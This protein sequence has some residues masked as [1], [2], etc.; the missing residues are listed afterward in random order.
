[1]F[2]YDN[3][4]HNLLRQAEQSAESASADTGAATD[5]EIKKIIEKAGRLEGLSHREV[6]QLLMC[7]DQKHLEL[8]FQTAA[9]VKAA[10]YGN[11]VV[12][13]APLYVSDWCVNKCAYCNY[14][15]LHQFGRSR[16]TQEQVRME[17]E[18]LEKMGHKRLALEA[19]Q[20]SENC[21]IE[22]ILE[23][24]DTIYSMKT[25]KGAIRRVNVNVAATSVEDYKKLKAAGIG[26]YI[27]FQ[28]TYHRPTYEKVHIAGPKKDFDYHLTALD[29]AME[30]GLDDVGG[31]A[32]FG[33]YDPYFEVLGL[34][35]HNEHLEKN[36]GVGFHTVSV[37]RLCKADGAIAAG[38]LYALSD[39][40]FMK[41]TAVLR[42]AIPFTG[43]IV[44]TRE[45]YALRKKLINIGVS[46]I[47]AGSVT[48]VGGY[49][50]GLAA[51]SVAQF[52][53]NDNSKI[54][55]IASWL[56]DE[57]LIPSFCTACYRSGRTGGRFMGL[58][59]TGKIKNVCQPN[60][61]MTLWEYAMD[62]GS[63]DFV[64][65]TRALIKSELENIGDEKIREL[66]AGNI[67]KI[68]NGQRDL[69]V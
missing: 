31:G 49:S 4:I 35:L 54:E 29:R 45:S 43:I 47:S 40:V 68:Q 14:N 5:A 26:S 57:N 3:Y 7:R 21:P 9:K 33:L 44:S 64:E 2:I 17:V 25:G 46:Q 37:P 65:K 53:K 62:Y 58:A 13:F 56:L 39:E 20:D 61:L 18:V 38:Y 59:K 50:A 27:L 22:Y 32:L 6:A 23:C 63:S 30:A 48:K 36:Y 8:I 1:V 52:E 67:E 16:L 34:M 66:T 51:Q 60:A 12:M 24:L 11:R 42:L 41:I 28:E 69:F 15:S 55:D 10:V 19:G